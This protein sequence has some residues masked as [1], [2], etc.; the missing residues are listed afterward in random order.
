MVFFFVKKNF[1]KY[2]FDCDF[3]DAMDKMKKR[4]ASGPAVFHCANCYATIP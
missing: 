2:I 4:Q 1:Q 3:F